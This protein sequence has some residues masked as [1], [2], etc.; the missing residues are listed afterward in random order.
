MDEKRLEILERAS[1]VY[2]KYGIKSVTM[3]DL[4]RELGI[5]KKTIYKYFDDKS[6]LVLSILELKVGMDQALCMNCE[7]TTENAIDHLL[8]ISEMIVANIGKI[9]PA[10]F[11]DLKKY[12]PEAWQRVEKH[13]MEFILNLIVGN[14]ERGKK[15]GLYRANLNSGVIGRIYVGSVDLIF[16]VD[17]FPWP[18]FTF[19]E[20]Y[21]QMIQFHIKG[22]VNNKGL[23]YLKQKLNNEEF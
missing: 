17:Y 12:H 9:S 19:Q 4:A 13:R 8:Q 10:V 15:E 7:H 21:S 14:V 2:M 1:A 18:Q 16:N 6:E 23:I 11:F 22:L 5:S 3:D 20:V